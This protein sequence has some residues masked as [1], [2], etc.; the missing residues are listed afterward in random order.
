[1]VNVGLIIGHLSFGGAEKQL[2]LL[3][4]GLN[5]NK[6]NPIVFCLSKAKEPWGDRIALLGIKIIYISRMSRFDITRIVRMTYFFYK[7][8]IDIIVSY[9]HIAI[10]YSFLARLLYFKNSCF[11]AQIRSKENSMNGLVKCLNVISLN[12]AN[13]I[14]TNST[15]LNSFVEKD[16]RQK[17]DKIITINNGIEVAEIK[18]DRKNKPINI[19]TI[20][21]D[22]PDKNIDLFVKMGLK[23]LEKYDNIN[24]F[25]CGRDLDNSSRFL[26]IIPAQ[27]LPLFHFYGEVNDPIS[28]YRILDIYIST[29]NSEGLPN[30]IMEA[31]SFG[32]PIACAYRS[33]MPEILQD[34]AVFFDPDDVNDICNQIAYLLNNQGVCQRLAAI[35]YQRAL[36]HDWK[37]C[38][39]RTLEFI[40][41]A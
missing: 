28:I 16:F 33:A 12:S 9:L 2:Y 27:F 10:V 1:M 17:N 40:C 11:I 39:N 22:T 32:I 30:T 5:R 13:V 41:A 8:D 23:L 15:L 21:K 18:R 24:F 31:M 25:L 7:N 3:C 37:T 20:G 35:A 38:A 36:K 6:I 4:K 19:G 34:A 29:S 26:K 14:I